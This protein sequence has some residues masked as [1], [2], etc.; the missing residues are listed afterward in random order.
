[1]DG[2]GILN[3]LDNCPTVSN[4]TQQD[5]DNDGIGDACDNDIDGDGIPNAQDNCR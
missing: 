2:D 1:M 3:V 5:L 4:T